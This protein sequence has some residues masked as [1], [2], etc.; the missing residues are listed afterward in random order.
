MHQVTLL[1]YCLH[2]SII[3]DP[4]YFSVFYALGFVHS[5]AASVRLFL[6]LTSSHALSW[7]FWSC[8]YLFLSI[9]YCFASFS[10]NH[11][12]PHEGIQYLFSVKGHKQVNTNKKTFYIEL[13]ILSHVYKTHQIVWILKWSNTISE[14]VFT[15]LWW[16]ICKL[17]TLQQLKQSTILCIYQPGNT[18]QL[19][20]PLSGSDPAPNVGLWMLAYARKSNNLFVK[21]RLQGSPQKTSKPGRSTVR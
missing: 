2:V 17:T 4:K 3:P 1:S 9:S 20:P 10:E 6:G 8:L 19:Y 12:L 15:L 13:K 16:F 11:S 5:S 18:S 14:A 21:G 7:N